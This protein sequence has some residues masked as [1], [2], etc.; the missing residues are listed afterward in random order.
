MIWAG[1][2]QI[3]LDKNAELENKAEKRPSVGSAVF[4]AKVWLKI[5]LVF[6]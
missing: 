4:K 5:K 2:R 6:V 1:I 3:K